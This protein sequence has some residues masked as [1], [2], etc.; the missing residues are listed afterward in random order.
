MAKEEVRPPTPQEILAPAVEFEKA[1]YQFHVAPL[2]AMGIPVPEEPP[3]PG[4]ATA[5]HQMLRGGGSPFPF[6]GAEEE[7]KEG[8]GVKK[9]KVVRETE[10]I[11]ERVVRA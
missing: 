2:R 4:P 8:E 11:E 9:E 3:V 1:I 6:L 7:G 10:E 5:L